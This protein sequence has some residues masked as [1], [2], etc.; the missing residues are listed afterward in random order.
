MRLGETMSKPFRTVVT[1]ESSDF[2]VSESKDYYINPDC[3]GDGLARWLLAE[4][5]QK[6]ISTDNEPDQEDFG[7]FFNFKLLNTEYCLIVGHI[8]VRNDNN[9][10]WFLA[11]ERNCGSLA[12]MFGGRKRGLNKVSAEIIHSVLSDSS[13]INKIRW[14]YRNNFHRGIHDLG[15]S[16]P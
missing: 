16:K 6:G 7:W 14:H 3:F 4:L 8:D 10:K 15:E 13:L 12:S 11:L 2:N 9:A 5:K 1:F